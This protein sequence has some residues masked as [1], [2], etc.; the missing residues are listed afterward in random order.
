MEDAFE[1]EAQK[2]VKKQVSKVQKQNMFA[3]YMERK[4]TTRKLPKSLG[5][6]G[7]TMHGSVVKATTVSRVKSGLFLTKGYKHMPHKFVILPFSM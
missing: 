5:S 7:A 1:S 4:Q 6:V 3:I 2:I